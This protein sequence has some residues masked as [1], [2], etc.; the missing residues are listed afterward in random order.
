MGWLESLFGTPQAIS[1]EVALL[2]LAISAVA[3]GLVGLERESRRQAAGLRTHMLICVGSALLMIVSIA[4]PAMIGPPE[5]DPAR[6]AAQVVS[7]IGFLGAGAIIKLGGTIKGL[8]TAA[9]IW[10]VSAIGLCVGAGLYTIGGIAALVSVFILLVLEKFEKRF[11]PHARLKT[12]TVAYAKARLDSKALAAAL[13]AAGA[14][15]VSLDVTH[16]VEKGKVR[17]S[18]EAKLPE[19]FDLASLDEPLSRFGKV[20]R[21]GIREEF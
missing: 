12:I 7:G 3:G 17:V 16:A 14:K 13:E 19:G 4:M 18:V 6:I 10:T 1:P 5:A 11:I 15:V 20:E 21:L 2:R 9:S 8:T